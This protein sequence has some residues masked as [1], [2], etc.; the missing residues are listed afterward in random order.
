MRNYLDLLEKVIAKGT[1]LPN[2]TGV[3]AIMLPGQTLEF[4]LRDGFPVVT[5]RKC[6]LEQVKGEVIGYLRGY[7]NAEK[8][9]ELGCRWWDQ[10]ANENEEWLR[11]PVRKGLDDLG[12]IYGVQWRHWRSPDGR[13]IDQVIR[14]LTLLHAQPLDRRI[15]IT[16][17]NPGELDQMALPPCPMD[18]VFTPNPVTRE[19]NLTMLQRS[20]DLYL[21]V[22]GDNVPEAALILSIFAYLTGYRAAKM[23]MV[24]ANAHIYVNHLEQIEEQL[25]REPLPLPT[26]RMSDRIAPYDPSNFNPAVIDEI[27]PGDLLI[28]GYQCHSALKKAAMAV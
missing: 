7:G 28:E 27:E 25:K 23:T 19:L 17:W 14:A 21:G 15:I 6:S 12:R 13:E 2:R 26:F 3:D 18:W 1:R 10:N 24:L 8:F 20:G 5:T 4:D 9:R 22:G 11:N 16:A